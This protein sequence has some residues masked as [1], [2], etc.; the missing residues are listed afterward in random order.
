MLDTTVTRRPNGRRVPKPF[1]LGSMPV[2][3]VPLGRAFWRRLDSCPG[4]GKI[5]PSKVN[6][7]VPKWAYDAFVARYSSKYPKAVTCLTKDEDVLFTFYRFPA[8]HWRHLRTT[9]PIE[10]TFATVRHRTR[11]TKG[12]GSRTATM[13][14]VYKLVIEAQ[15]QWRRLNGHVLLLKVIEGLIVCSRRRRPMDRIVF[16]H[17]LVIAFASRCRC[18]RVLQGAFRSVYVWRSVVQ[19]LVR[20]PIR[21]LTLFT[22]TAR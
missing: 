20:L 19:L 4:I 1:R 8:E 10:S 3:Q 16:I 7:T 9:N 22:F 6:L 12:C 21:F 14:M 11:Q 5:C 13:A 15:K 18:M 2:V 17:L